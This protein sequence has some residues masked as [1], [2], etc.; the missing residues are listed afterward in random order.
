[1]NRTFLNPGIGRIA[2]LVPFIIL[3]LIVLD[4]NPGFGSEKKGIYIDADMQYEYAQQCF[5]DNDPSLALVELKRFIHFF[6]RDKR[7]AEA[8]FLTGRAYY[9]LEKYEEALKTF[10]TFLFPFS[11]DTLVIESYF[12]MAKT[13]GRMDREGKAETV[14]QNLLLLTDEIAT[15]DRAH[16]ALGWM[17][18]KQSQSMNPLDLEKAGANINR[19]SNARAREYSRD[20]VN[21]TISS[22]WKIKKKSPTIAGLSAVF[23]GMGFLYCERYQDALVSFLLNTALILAAHES[24]DNGNPA[25]GGVITFVEAGFYA[26]NI[27]GSISSAHKFNLLAHQRNLELL[28]QAVEPPL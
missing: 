7:I 28:E 21:E 12:M 18:L 24:F 10:K 11:E 5:N 15:K 26:G 14:L 23:P 13:F 19:I 20:R 25:L 3:I 2:T 4:L 9:D 22:L 17:A 27:Y 1:M 16:A 8:L 6:P